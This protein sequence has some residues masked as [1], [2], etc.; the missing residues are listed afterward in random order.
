[1][2]LLAATLVACQAPGRETLLPVLNFGERRAAKALVCEVSRSQLKLRTGVLRL[3]WE[4]PEKLATDR[5]LDM[6]VYKGGFK[7]GGFVSFPS[8]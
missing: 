1:M 8:L 4:A 6:T 3:S 7:T 5:R 2:I